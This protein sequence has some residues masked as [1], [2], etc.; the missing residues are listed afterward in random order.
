M[1]K[2]RGFTLIELLVVIAIIAVLMGILMPTLRKVKEQGN[3]IKCMGNLKQWNLVHAM[4]L[5]E[6]DGK[7]YSGV[8]GSAF[9]WISQMNDKDESWIKN[10]TWFC[11]KNKNMENEPDGSPG[12]SLSIHTAWGVYRPGTGGEPAGFRFNPDGVAG[13][14][15]INGYVLGLT[16]GSENMSENRRASDFFKTPQV[17]GAGQIPLMAE[18]LRFDLFPQP[19]DPPAAREDAVW[20][21][22]NHMARAC[23][24]RHV[25]Y[26]N[27]SMCDFSVRKVGLKE[28]YTLKWH[29]T[30]NVAGPFTLAGGVTADKWPDWIRP[31]KDY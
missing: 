6:N 13:S 30:F 23:M 26:V 27:I 8:P 16:G 2:N 1:T 10:P 12:G 28:L 7:F 20:S 31:F 9:Y 24:N 17:K 5:Q 29:K 19:T 15:G 4:Y 11:P 14:Y 22:N 21:S 3:M 18:S 25:G